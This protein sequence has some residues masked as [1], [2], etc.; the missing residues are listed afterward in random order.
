MGEWLFCAKFGSCDLYVTYSFW[1]QTHCHVWAADRQ[2]L[3]HPSV[4]GAVSTFQI[5]RFTFVWQHWNSVLINI[6]SQHT[7]PKRCY[8][9]PHPFPLTF[10]ETQSH[11]SKGIFRIHFPSSVPIQVKITGLSAC[12]FSCKRTT[13]KNQMLVWTGNVIWETFR[14]VQNAASRLLQSL[15][16]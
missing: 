10:R 15:G 11:T 4:S 8:L 16:K 9:L 14:D 2:R 6:T 3:G 1:Q 7:V 12:F 5:Q 13:S